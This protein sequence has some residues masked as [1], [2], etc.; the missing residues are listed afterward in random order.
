MSDKEDEKSKKVADDLREEQEK[1]VKN[2][3]GEMGL[4]PKEVDTILA[5][6]GGP[7]AEGIKPKAAEMSVPIPQRGSASRTTVATS[8]EITEE[9]EPAASTP[10][11]EHMFKKLDEMASTVQSLERNI[12]ASLSSE[13]LEFRSKLV[14][15]RTEIARKLTER[16]RMKAFAPL[17]ENAISEVVVAE[18]KKLEETLLESFSRDLVGKFKGFREELTNSKYR[19]LASLKEQAEIYGA[20]GRSLE[21]EL[22]INEKQV[23]ELKEQVAKRDTIMSEQRATMSELQ[24][25]VVRLEEELNEAASGAKTGIEVKELKARLENQQQTIERLRSQIIETSEIKAR[26]KAY[27][28]NIEEKRKKAEELNGRIIELEG[29]LA[30]TEVRAGDL[31]TQNKSFRSEVDRIRTEN[32]DVMKAK[33]RA[34]ELETAYQRAKQ[35]VQDLKSIVEETEDKFSEKKA[36]VA[37][38]VKVMSKEPKY[39]ILTILK[40]LGT[41]SFTEIARAIGQPIAI[42]RRYSQELQQDGYVKIDDPNVTGVGEWAKKSS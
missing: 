2:L 28:D 18:V 34:I 41:L 6:T 35:E 11:I 22:T 3:L 13:L 42:A 19:L 12:A 7:I 40:D 14:D 39:K 36:E 29:K 32:V 10:S 9:Q 4:T 21:D 23:R 38:I 15:L 30:E 33:S 1:V 17:V 24:G 31:E 8:E 16:L 37:R 5:P 25:N 27:E 20:H 26:L